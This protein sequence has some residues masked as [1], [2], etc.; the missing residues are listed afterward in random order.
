MSYRRAAKDLDGRGRALLLEEMGC[1]EGL[2]SVAEGA[3]KLDDLPC[4]IYAYDNGGFYYDSPLVIAADYGALCIIEYIIRVKDEVVWPSHFFCTRNSTWNKAL[5]LA[6][7]RGYLACVRSLHTSGVPLWDRVIVIPDSWFSCGKF[8][9]RYGSPETCLH[10]PK[11]R[12]LAR[13]LWSVLRYGQMHGAPL[14]GYAGWVFK[15][16]QE[17]ARQVMRCFHCAARLSRGGGKHARL[18]GL[19]AD[20]PADVVYS[21]LVTAELEMEEAFK[22]RVPCLASGFDG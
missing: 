4:F 12:R 18:W 5:S 22:P 1:T 16:R 19:M 13:S 21:I 7:A 3:A 15:E 2:G 11:S 17:R 8:L 9:L 14:P 6:A 20:V 10:V